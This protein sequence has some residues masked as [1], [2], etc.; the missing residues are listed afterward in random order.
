MYLWNIQTITRVPEKEKTLALADVD[1]RARP[2][3]SRTR[4]ESELWPQQVRDQPR[5]GGHPRE[6]RWTVT[7]IEEKDADS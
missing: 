1:L 5:T 6:V 7:H 4:L 3:K 2:C